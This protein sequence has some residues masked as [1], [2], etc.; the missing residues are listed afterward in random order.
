MW[1]ILSSLVRQIRT[2]IEQISASFFPQK[3]CSEKA[4]EAKNLT[5]ESAYVI[6]KP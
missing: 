4:K 2:M 1:H 3:K 5:K 6:L